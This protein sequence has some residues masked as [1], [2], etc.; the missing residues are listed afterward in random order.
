M[1]GCFTFVLALVGASG[2]AWAKHRTGATE[3]RLHLA[4]AEASSY[5]VNDWNKFSANYLPLYIGDDDPQTAW[6]LKTEG[7]N[8]WIRM[9]VTPMEGATKVRLRIRNGYQKSPRLFAANSRVRSL[10]VVL[11]P[12]KI[13]TIVELKDASGWQEIVVEQPTGPMDGVEFHIQSVYPGSKYDDLC[14]S[15]VQ[16]HVSATSPENPAYE[17][18]RFTKLLSWKSERLAAAKLFQ[19]NLEKD[20]AH[21][22]GVFCNR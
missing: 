2:N 13:E 15:D 14:L 16:I 3:R 10:K 18:Q 7:I 17:K 22:F 11:F 8:E 6:T 12:S 1:T 5:L 9:R 20:V 21:I 4:I 19:S